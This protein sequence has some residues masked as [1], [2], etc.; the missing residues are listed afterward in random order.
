[1]NWTQQPKYELTD[2]GIQQLPKGI[3]LPNNRTLMNGIQ[4]PN[5]HES[6]T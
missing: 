6:T 3:L 4:Q 5:V 1:M 2:W